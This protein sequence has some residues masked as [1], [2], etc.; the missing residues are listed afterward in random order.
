MSETAGRFLQPSAGQLTADVTELVRPE[1]RFDLRAG[2][3]NSFERGSSELSLPIPLSIDGV[4]KRMYLQVWPILNGG[5]RP[6]QAL[7][8]FIEGAV[9]TPYEDN[10]IS[11]AL[12]DATFNDRVM[13]LQEEL[14][15]T[16]ARLRTSRE[17]SESANEELR[18]ANE[19]LQ[20]VNEEY[21]STA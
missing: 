4:R 11:S 5:D 14:E 8:L 12:H 18:A 16:R 3:H 7:I 15:L 9:I 10:P 20:S 17:E 1:L 2:L 19:E 6:D 21:R 13:S